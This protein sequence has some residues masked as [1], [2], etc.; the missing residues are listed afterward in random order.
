[1][2]NMKNPKISRVSNASA[3]KRII[4]SKPMGAVVSKYREE[5]VQ[6]KLMYC[7]VQLVQYRKLESK[8]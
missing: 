4:A 3:Q 5:L 2:Q 6:W 8:D 1:M 7:N